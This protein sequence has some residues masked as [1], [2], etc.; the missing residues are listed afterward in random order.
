MSQI[1]ILTNDYIGTEMAGPA[2]RC[3]EMAAILSRE[4]TVTL[5]TTMKTTVVT[6]KFCVMHV[7]VQDLPQLCQWADFIIIQPIVLWSFPFLSK[8]PKPIIVDVY[9]VFLVESLEA[10]KHLT[11][12]DRNVSHQHNLSIAKKLLKTGDFFLCANE[13]QKD[14]WLGMLSYANRLSADLYRENSFCNSL[15]AIVPNG[16]SSTL[17]VHRQNVVKGVLKSVRPSDK[18]LIWGGSICNWFD[19]VTLI[20]AVALL[21]QKRDDIKLLFLGSKAPNKEIPEYI[22]SEMT[23]AVNCSKELGVYQQAVIFNHGWI[24]YADRE[25]YLLEAD[26][27]VSLHYHNLE[28]HYS[29]RTRILDYLWAGLP[30]ITCEGDF[31]AD[32]VSRHHLG[33]V[34]P[35]QSPEDVAIAITNLLD[36]RDDYLSCKTNIKAIR[37]TFYWENVM[38][39]LVEYCGNPRIKVKNPGEVT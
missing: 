38:Q 17:P 7:T 12:Q 15:V 11:L 32:L 29:F 23:R 20:Q 2:I 8:V 33:S 22:W 35:C 14:F 26:L 36:N 18:L 3:W 39:P 19:P 21:K 10:N 30:I 16:M 37:P 24:P 9:N 27:G 28:T 6:E 5:G 13:R 4:H 25:N 1:L 34:V 31:M